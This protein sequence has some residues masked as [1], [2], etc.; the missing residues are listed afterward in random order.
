MLDSA[1]G[2]CELT[3]LANGGVAAGDE[4]RQRMRR[5]WG[6]WSSPRRQLG[7]HRRPATRREAAACFGSQRRWCSG[8]APARVRS[9]RGRMRR[10]EAEGEVDGGGAPRE[11]TE[12]LGGWWR[13]DVDSGERKGGGEMRFWGEDEEEEGHL[14]LL[15]IGQRGCLGREIERAKMAAVD[16]RSSELSTIGGG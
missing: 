1:G 3:I 13:G 8:D 12:D 2:A 9:A 10:G 4:V 6:G 16:A 15:F 11:A 14:E 5:R 7:L